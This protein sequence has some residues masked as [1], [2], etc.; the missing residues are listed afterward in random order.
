MMK[1]AILVLISLG[2]LLPSVFAQV[3]VGA[4]WNSD[5]PSVLVGERVNL[6]LIVEVPVEAIVTFPEIPTDWE[7]FEVQSLGEIS[8]AV[9]GDI[10]T[11]RQSLTV[12]AWRT[13]EHSTPETYIEYQLSPGDAV[14]RILV[15]PTVISV[16]SVLDSHDTELRPLKPPVVLPYLPPWIVLLAVAILLGAYRSRSWWRAHLGTG[17]RSARL[18]S[19]FDKNYSPK[20][21]VM[22]EIATLRGGRLSA[23]YVYEAVSDCLRTYLFQQ[24]SVNAPEMTTVELM[25]TLE[26]KQIMSQAQQRDL[27]RMLDYADLVKFADAQPGERAV[28]QLLDS[29]GKWVEAIEPVE[30]E[31]PS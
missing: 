5:S 2:I 16:P 18:T 12:I 28:K 31:T 26:V 6:V 9:S 30:K 13:G 4:R 23:T 7:P 29:A 19:A 3:P 20:Q 15:E 25:S 17:Q 27:A 8:K 21:S 14:Q 11:Y 22:A 1:R 10:A 24:F